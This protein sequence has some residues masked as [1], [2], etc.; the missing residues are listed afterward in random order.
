MKTVS[1]IYDGTVLRLQ[2]PLVLA[3]GQVVHVLVPD[4]RD[5]DSKP[6]MKFVGS[7]SPEDGKMMLDAIEA[8]FG[9]IEPDEWD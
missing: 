7:I 4:A 2:E 3:K 6:W 8:E 9:R 1:A 5:E